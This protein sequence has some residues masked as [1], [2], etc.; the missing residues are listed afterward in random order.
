M[1]KALV[2]MSGGLDSLLAAKL[3]LESGVSVTGLVFKSCFFNSQSGKAGCRQLKIPCKIIDFSKEHLKVVKE[4]FY[5]WG[6]AANPCIDCHLLMLKKAKKILEKEGW[7]FIATG[8][9]LGERPFSQN[10]QALFLIA[11]KSG[12]KDKLLRPLSAKL[13]P[14]TL[15]EKKGWVKPEFLLA[16]QGRRRVEQIKLAGRYDL[17]Y[18]APAGGCILC[19]KEFS[20]KLFDLFKKWSDCRPK[21]VDLLKLGRH[22]WHKKAKIVLGKNKKENEKLG[23]IGIKKDV[24]IIPEN[25]PGPTGLI[26]VLEGESF[27]VLGFREKLVKKAKELILEHS[28]KIPNRVKYKTV[29]INRNLDKTGLK[30]CENN[31][32]IGLDKD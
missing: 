12:L 19:E 25:F 2:L 20:K 28:K 30:K 15:P 22:F 7:D 32:N 5:G 21:D 26:R 8:E 16:I 23:K 18:P 11:E 10:K 3:L 17:I 13:L 9:V 1:K 29:L 14:K 6:K 27:R 31:Q 4:P 24:L